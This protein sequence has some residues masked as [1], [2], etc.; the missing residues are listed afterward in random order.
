M[1][2]LESFRA[3]RNERRGDLQI[4]DG[5]VVVTRELDGLHWHVAVSSEDNRSILRTK[6]QAHASSSCVVRA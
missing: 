4:R 5:I 3:G 6:F 1:A 2:S